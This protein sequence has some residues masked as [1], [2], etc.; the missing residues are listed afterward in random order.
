MAKIKM[1][2]SVTVTDTFDDFLMAK[3]AGGLSEK[4]IATYGQHF[5]AISKHLPTHAPIDRRKKQTWRP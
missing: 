4:A 2:S 1:K 5:S 3:K